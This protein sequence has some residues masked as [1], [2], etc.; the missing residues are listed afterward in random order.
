MRRILLFFV[1]LPV[2]ATAQINDDFSDGDFTS[3]PV[4]AGDTGDFEVD[5]NFQLHL[6]AVAQT[7]E[8][9]LSTALSLGGVSEWSFYLNMDFNPSGSN[10]FDFHLMSDSSNLESD[11][12]GYFLRIGGTDDEVSLFRK[13]G[14]T[15]TK[16]I[17]GVDDRVN[18]DPV[19]V[20]IKV[21]RLANGD[22]KVYSR[23][24][25]ENMY[26]LE[27]EVND[28]TYTATAFC[29][30][31][32]DYTSTRST[33]FWFDDFGYNLPPKVLNLNVQDSVTL[34]VTFDEAINQIAAETESNYSVNGGIGNPSSATMLTANEVELSF[35]NAFTLA[36]NYALTISAVSDTLGN[37]ISS[38]VIPFEYLQFV[39]PAYRDIVINEIMADPTP[40]TALPELEFVEI[41]NTTNN[42]IDITGAYFGDPST[43]G[44][45][46]ANTII[47]PNAYLI[48]C[49]EDDISGF[50]SYGQVLG[51]SA[52]PGLNNSGDVLS[53]YVDSVLIDRIEY[54]DTWYADD[55][56][57]DGGYT[58]E[59]INPANPCNGISNWAASNDAS[60]GTPGQQ[61]SVFNAA[62]DTT[63]PTILTT[64]LANSNTII[65]E[66]SKGMDSLSIAN[67]S[68]TMD[69]GVSVSSI[70]VSSEP[71]SMATLSLSASLDSSVIYTLTIASGITDCIGN[72]LG[73]KS[74]QL[75]IG[76]SPKPFDIIIN[77]LYPDPDASSGLPEV[78]FVEIYN[79]SEK[80][81]RLEGLSLSDASSSSDLFATTL[82]P[83]EYAIVCDDAEFSTF[84]Q[85][86]KVAVVSS[87]PSLNNSSDSI[88]LTLGETTIDAVF[89]TDDWYGNE[90][91]SDGGYTLERINPND[92]CGTSNNWAASND[93]AGGTPGGENS[94]AQ[95]TDPGNPQL[96]SGSF[97]TLKEIRLEFDRAMDIASLANANVTSNGSAL[98]TA[99]IEA[100]SLSL[101]GSFERGKEYTIMIDSAS[102][103]VGLPLQTSS[104]QLYLPSIND[105]VIN[106][107]LFNPRES[108]TDFV[109]L[110]NQSG[111][112][113]NLKGWS[114]AYYD[115]KDS[116]RFNSL[117]SSTYS[118]ESQGFVA[119]NEDSANLIKN[120]P[121]S[122]P[123][124]FHTMNLPSY[125]NTEGSVM[126]YDQLGEL[127][128]QFDYNEDMH[129]ALIDDPDGVS[130]ERLD[131]T[132]SASDAGNWHS[133]ASGDNYATPGYVNSQEYAS[134]AG[135]AN[136]SLSSEYISPDNDG[137]Q[138]VVNIE[139][140]LG[141][142]GHV[143]TISV[144]TDRG[145]LI[146]K[147][148]TNQVLG[149][150]G[151]I[152]WDG[153]NDLGEKARTGIHVILVETFDLDGN[154]ARFRLPIV[155]ATR[156]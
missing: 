40:P 54:T 38:E 28:L 45:V 14:N 58:L 75:G 106:E 150:R 134:S 77:E 16:I 99:T 123:S 81:L 51:L 22:W 48:L 88:W 86:G 3:N 131:A 18:L 92:L 125:S 117:T 66:F 9:H 141:E 43:I 127:I 56:K 25:S 30:V 74:L 55:D 59:Q 68:F 34:V 60:G 78:E 105:V 79:R 46:L 49:D 103:C 121:Q 146:R 133:A 147:I 87:M 111:Y 20:F 138:D 63:R 128:E 96:I 116:L 36:S 62:P 42:Y 67:A 26:N 143:A 135:E 119:L 84:S 120:Y 71:H 142:P 17:D 115:S 124:N 32:C 73:A 102:D 13:D 114:L 33:L 137:Y 132:R 148:A 104:I 19:S 113:I 152:T 2:L 80:L 95:I 4:W 136:F 126:V 24:E 101:K 90:D 57:D 93:S 129:F 31:H 109:E 27:G 37:A 44:S 155:V 12:N 7:D 110:Y 6:N 83:N 61:N 145:V 53:L 69:N 107:V 153:T 39:T 21:L 41:Y 35:S 70:S 11:H 76:V 15:N 112:N 10:L 89:Y 130:L 50:S 23:I 154:N 122:E 149:N 144:Y 47:E 94:I 100:T 98:S 5:A 156:L 151:S 108:G 82:L 1:V 118:L 85:Y 52:F 65:I 64:E 72:G 140:Q 29:G 91:K 97:T 139:Y 8:S